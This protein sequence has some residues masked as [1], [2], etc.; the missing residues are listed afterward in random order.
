M[1]YRPIATSALSVALAL[2]LLA[3]GAA[4]AASGI[5][6][7]Y[8]QNVGTESATIS[9]ATIR[10]QATVTPI[11]GSPQALQATAPAYEHHSITLKDLQPGT[12]Y[13]YD[14]LADGSAAGKGSFTTTPEGDQ[15]FTFAIVSDTQ[16][17][18]NKALEGV[19]KRLLAEKPAFVVSTGDTVSDGEDAADWQYFFEVGADLMRTTPW[20]AVLGNHDRHAQMYF[21]FWSL[22]GNEAYYSFDRGTSHFVVLDSPGL[23]WPENNQSESE[24]LEAWEDEQNT[25]YM[26]RQLEWLK[27]DLAGAKDAKYIFV[28]FHYPPYTA[29]R[30]R[31]DGAKQVQ[32]FF[33]SIFQDHQVSAVFTGHDHHYH[34]A[35]KGGV[36]FV[37]AGIGGGRP[38]EIQ[39]KQP[40]TVKAEQV[41][42]YINVSVNESGA[43]VKVL[44]LDG[45]EIDAL[46]IKPRAVTPAAAR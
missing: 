28:F 31:D 3:A 34:R 35:A 10:G 41:S 6:G 36:P 9:W 19:I 11:S 22:P 1:T 26:Q 44:D 27:G 23:R 8:V 21:D 33:G 16:G 40:E 30:N 45:K 29:L 32:A 15:P 2:L 37:T 12:T 17:T 20:Y 13:A 39:I 38:R 7:P 42:G 14:V 43:A 25:A 46:S 5:L 4:F 18:G 24:A